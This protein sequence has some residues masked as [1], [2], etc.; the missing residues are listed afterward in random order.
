MSTVDKIL[1]LLPSSWEEVSLRKFHKLMDVPTVNKEEDFSGIRATLEIVHALTDIPREELNYLLMKD[2]ALIGKKL[3]FTNTE[4]PHIES[5]KFDW[6]KINEI[7]MDDFI[8]FLNYKDDQIRNLDS[9]ILTFNKNKLTR[10]QIL[11]LP[12]GEVLHGFF[13]YKQYVKKFLNNL[14]ESEQRK[15]HLKILKMKAHLILDKVRSK[16]IGQK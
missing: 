4:I 11:E 15:L 14:I 7:T 1:E 10:E 8:Y 13:L 6:K 12:I 5:K 16:L 2:F 9:F 3:E